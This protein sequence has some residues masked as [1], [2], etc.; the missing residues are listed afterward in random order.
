MSVA[1]LVCCICRFA[2]VK[3]VCLHDAGY[4][5]CVHMSMGFGVCVCLSVT[6]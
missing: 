2:F 4:D 6:L 3:S 1:M 5:I